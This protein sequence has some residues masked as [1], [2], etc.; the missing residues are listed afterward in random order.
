[1]EIRHLIT[2]Q[3][4]VDKGSYTGAAAKLGYTQST[5]TT[6]IQ[7]LEQEIGGA[8]F[9][10]EKRRLKLTP[11]GRE[12]IPLAEDL[13][14]A[15][16]KIKNMQSIHEVKGVLKI[17]APESL[18]ISRL[19]PIIREYSMKYPNVN[20]ILSNGTCGQNQVELVSGRVDIAFMVYPEIQMEKCIHHSLLEERI[21]LVAGSD[22]PE[23]FDDYQQSGKHFFITNEE[24][25]SYRTMFERF[26]VKH[27]ISHLQ[28]M[29]LWSIE[30]IKQTV[31]SGL[32]FSVLPYITVKEEVKAGKLK[33]LQQSEPFERLYSH[34]LVKKKKWQLPA[35]EA[36]VSLVLESFGDK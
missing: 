31:M 11:L 1:M 27:D 28:I 19:G 13:L 36:F 21:V 4:I 12:L 14:S 18:T 7:A 32:G 3:A 15:H 5:I 17:A 2:F 20:I 8:L 26:L 24:G 33:I 9:T 22:A 35:A 23:H 16:D 30:A 29:E 34:M 6:H 10:Y 25:C